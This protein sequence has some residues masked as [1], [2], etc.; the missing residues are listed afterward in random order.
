M[1]KLHESCF[2]CP[3][4]RKFPIHT[5]DDLIGSYGAY[6]VQRDGFDQSRRDEIEGNFTKAAA[7]YGVE[8]EPPK[9]E[10]APRQVLMFK[11]ASEAIDMTEVKTTSELDQA[12]DF[13]LEK[14]ASVDRESLAE[15]AK[16]LL[17]L[18]ANSDRSLDSDKMRKIAH[19]AGIG[20][21]DRGEIQH[22]IERRGVENHLDEVSKAA[23]YKFAS[24]VRALSDEEF[25]N[26]HTL[27]TICKVLD[28]CDRMYGNQHKHASEGYPEDVVFKSTMDDLIKEASDLY[29]VPSIDATLSKKATLER[30]DAINSFFTSLYGTKSELDGEALLKKVASL[31]GRLANALVGAIG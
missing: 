17:W 5:K 26:E 16:Y 23:L 25:Y 29:Y 3:S 14:R 8:L 20:V 10:P 30:K 6:K 9:K 24:D 27:N 21:G 11:G 18:T 4:L 15:P 31:D 12:I 28:E 7:Y 13:I 19:I 2:A 1:S 22:E